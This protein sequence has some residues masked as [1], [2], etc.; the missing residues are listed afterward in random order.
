MG[1][2]GPGVWRVAAQEHEGHLDPA[3]GAA[4][5]GLPT[6]L[7]LLRGQGVGGSLVRLPGQ[8]QAGREGSE[9][10]TPA[11]QTLQL[12]QASWQ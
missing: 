1:T 7:G 3:G 9:G 10:H 6:G 4:S 2:P 11:S 12:K 8:A 5:L